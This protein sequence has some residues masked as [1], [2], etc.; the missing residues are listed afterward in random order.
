MLAQWGIHPCKDGY[1]GVAAMPRQSFAVYDR[2]G[3]PELKEDP[4]FASGWSPDANE[5]LQVLIPEWTAQH[6]AQEIFDLA[7]EFRAP[8]AMIPNARELLEWPALKEIGFWR[9]VEHPVLG[10][11]PLP[12]GPIDF[13]DGN[14]GSTQRAPLLGEHTEEARV[15]VAALPKPTREEGGEARPPLDGIRVVDVTAVW[16]GPY[17]TRFLA[18]MGAE[19]IKVEGPSFADPIRTMTGAQKAPEINASTYFNE[20]NRNKLGVSLDM[21]HPDGMEAF[22]RL[23][24]NSDVFVEN[25]SSGVAER[26]GL[27]YEELKKLNPKI[28]YVSMPGFGHTG[29]DAGRIG[30]GPT[31][32]QMG[33]LVALQGYG[34]GPPRRSGIS[35]GDPISGTTAAGAVALGLL[36]RQ[37]T[38]EST[39]AV[40]PQRDGI[41][42]LIG[43]YVVAEALGAPL[44]TRI[45][46][47]DAAMAPHNVYQAAD[48]APRP[49]IGVLGGAAGELTDGWITIAVDSE[50]AWGGLKRVIQDKRLDKAAFATMTSRH[51]AQDE[52]DGIIAEWA[53]S[54]DAGDAAAALQAAGVCAAPVLTP[55]TVTQDEHLLERE[56]F[57]TYDHPVTGTVGCSAPAWRMQRR[58]I[59]SVKAAPSFGQH[60]GDV[61]TRV[62]G[63]SSAELDVL[64][65]NQVTTD[66]L[67]PTT[68]G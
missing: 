6:T 31:I 67:L 3:H 59:T 62:A 65:E 51:E 8:F 12:A 11:H 55:L 40:V 23:I 43:E 66:D 30:F 10:E 1:V 49:L 26:L 32:E 28:I 7:S 27:G 19:V 50:D 34:E 42:Q 2:I 56:A 46:S 47:H 36:K 17:G 45:G 33:G 41:V 48:T 35:Y 61:L 64:R 13:D 9:T 54:R 21:K 58:P 5:L 44:P 20:Y 53:G 39:H 15:E 68:A 14:R 29:G 38:G 18:D 63:Y 60:T 24:A 25:W 22:R 16:A 4:A 57:L 37:R 52:L